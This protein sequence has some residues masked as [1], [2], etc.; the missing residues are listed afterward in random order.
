MAE[1]SSA[2][3]DLELLRSFQAAA[4]LGS[5][6]AAAEQRHR[7]VSAITPPRFGGSAPATALVRATTP[8]DA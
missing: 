4:Q 3:L 2:T 1:V 5:L 7:T 6:A 8:R